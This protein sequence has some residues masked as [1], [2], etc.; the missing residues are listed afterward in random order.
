MHEDELEAYLNLL[1]QAC[2]DAAG[3]LRR[4]VDHLGTWMAGNEEW[5]RCTARFKAHE[6]MT[7]DEGTT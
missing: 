7:I 1:P 3:P 6:H 5:S 2:G 4:F